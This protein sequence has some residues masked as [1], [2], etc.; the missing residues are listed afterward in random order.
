[1]TIVAL[2]V[3]RIVL[4]A[5]NG[6]LLLHCFDELS[7]VSVSVLLRIAM[8]VGFNLLAMRAQVTTPRGDHRVS[9]LRRDRRCLGLAMYGVGSYVVLGTTMGLLGQAPIR[10]PSSISG[11]R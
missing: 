8:I 7:L 3:A 5:L 1:V 2:L 10:S 11:R 4:F 6:E 9:E